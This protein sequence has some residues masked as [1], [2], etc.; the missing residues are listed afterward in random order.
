MNKPNKLQEGSGKQLNELRNQINEQKE[1]FTKE[2]GSLK[3][4]QYSLFG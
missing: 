4:N 3:N 1:N 2:I